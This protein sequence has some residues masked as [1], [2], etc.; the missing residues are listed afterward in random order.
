MHPCG[1]LQTHWLLHHEK[2]YECENST[3]RYDIDAIWM[4]CVHHD[5]YQYIVCHKGNRT[6]FSQYFRAENQHFHP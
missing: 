3:Y 2:H 6:A 1:I 4:H 5:Q